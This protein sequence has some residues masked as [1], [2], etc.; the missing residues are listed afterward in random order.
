MII[1]H[2]VDF[3][4]SNDVTVI[5]RRQFEAHFELYN[6][7]VEKYNQITQ[8]LQNE[9]LY[10]NAN[11]TYSEFRGLKRGETYALNGVILHELY[12]ENI[13]GEDQESIEVMIQRVL[14]NSFEDFEH[15]K[16]D[17]IATAKAS[18]GWVILAYVQ[19]TNRFLNISL[20]SHDFGNIEL[21]FPLLVLD[22]YEHAYFL[23]YGNKKQEYI[24]EF[25]KNINW[26]IVMR[27]FDRLT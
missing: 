23:Q 7:Y 22:V 12:F 4:Y 6:G 27:R 14:G 20:D 17:F 24:E 13:G 15:W 18:R 16:N 9:G 3:I 10:E 19:R 21:T 26:K 2:R 11:S 5:N 8:L 1:I 25:M